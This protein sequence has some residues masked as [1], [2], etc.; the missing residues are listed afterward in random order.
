M[1]IDLRRAQPTRPRV[2]G[3]LLGSLGLALVVLTALVAIAWGPLLD[4]DETIADAAFDFSVGHPAWVGV[5]ELIAFL[6]EP[7]I[8][9]LVLLVAAVVALSRREFRIAIWLLVVTVVENILAPLS[10]YLLDRPRPFERWADPISA[11]GGFSYP[12]GHAA[13]AGMFGTTLILLT[14]VLVQKG[15]V[16]RLLITLWAALWVIV[17]LD[18]IFLGV[19]Y[20]SDV[21]GGILLGT[22]IALGAWVGTMWNAV[23]ETTRLTTT[24]GTGGK[25]VAVILNP[26]KV[27]DVAAFKSRIANAA[28]VAGWQ[29]PHFYE[30]TI[31]DPGVSM[32]HDALEEGADLVIAAGGDG[33]VRLV[34]NELARTGVAV[35]VVPL[36]TGNLLARNLAIPLHTGDAID[37]A[38]KGQDR[39]ID[40]VAIEG[41]ELKSTAFTV[42]AGIGLDAAIMTGAPDELKAKVGW[43]A[44]VVSGVKQFNR[45]PATK[46][47]VSVDDGPFVKHRARTVVI[48]N[49][50]YLQAG[51]PLLPDALVDDGQLDVVVIAPARFTGWVRVAY[52]VIGKRKRTD[53]RLDRMTGTKVVVRADKPTP[54]QLD[55]DPIGETSELRA[56][57]MPGVLLVRVPH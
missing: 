47:Q 52:R 15:L 54:F 42:M 35:G 50:G 29:H 8:L 22:L 14:I 53:G 7:I 26:I 55:G 4:L 56:E 21:V 48:G 17:G 25:R 24:T 31:D 51:L 2:L 39:A 34:C 6:S 27:G 40:I 23:G 38:L 41:D 44:Y 28:G 45:Y 18:R 12:S 16:R 43:M 37:T 30:T 1:P 10:K 20:L 19:H 9:R 49:V 5:L 3:T 46:V 13:G 57:I 36:G 11:I 32:T 33:T